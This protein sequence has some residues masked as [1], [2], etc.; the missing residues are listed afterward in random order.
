RGSRDARG[1]GRPSSE[2]CA[3]ASLPYQLKAVEQR[4]CPP[5]CLERRGLGGAGLPLQ[6]PQPSREGAYDGG[7]RGGLPC[8]A[9]V[10]GLTGCGDEPPPDPMTDPSTGPPAGNPDGM[11]VVPAEAQPED[12]SQPR[13]VIGDGTPAS[14][15]SKAVV[16]AVAAGGVIT[17]KCG[18]DP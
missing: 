3:R 1:S 6:V 12:V 2:P 18:L 8:L 11:C 17:F 7:M 5:K 10:F 4:A 9:V 13:T 14:C 15:T 16:D